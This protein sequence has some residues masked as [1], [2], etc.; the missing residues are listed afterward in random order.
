MKAWLILIRDRLRSSFWFLPGTIGIAGMLL[1]IFMVLIDDHFGQAIENTLP[2]LTPRDPNA[3]RSL[4]ATLFGAIITAL[5]IVFSVTMVSLTLAVGQLGPRLLRNFMRDRGNQITLGIFV[6]T[7]LYCLV[8]LWMVGQLSN[9]GGLRLAAIGALLLAILS[10]GVLLYFVHHVSQMIQSPSVIAAVRAELDE[11]IDH[12]FP[13]KWDDHAA[14][15]DDGDEAADHKLY[16]RLPPDEEAAVVHAKSS[17]YIQGVNTSGIIQLAKQHDLLVRLRHRPGKFVTEGEQIILA[18]PAEKCSEQLACK[19]HQTLIFGNHRTP[20]QDVEFAFD[21]LVEVALRALSPSLNDPFTA[22]T[23]IDQLGACVAKLMQR[24]MPPTGQY[25]EQNKLRLVMDRVTFQGLVRT[26]FDQ[27]RQ[28]CA[29]E[30]IVSARLLETLATLAGHCRTDAQ[31]AA[32][33]QQAVMV[34]RGAK[35]CTDEQG[36]AGMLDRQFARVI[37]AIG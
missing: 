34:H 19:L 13:C 5:S 4:M 21:E 18:W 33:H 22:I 15:G 30:V 7:A 31:R 28:A 29:S 14:N 37:Q 27:I 26:A 16:D 23:C 24:K 20:A 2:W 36:D 6:A 25:D 3:M 11:L 32:I 1:A 35:A 12:H 10:L 9:A 17:G 8:V